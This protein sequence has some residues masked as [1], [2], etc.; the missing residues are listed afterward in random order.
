MS[1]D[2]NIY[3]RYLQGDEAAFDEI[4]GEYRLKLIFF[5]QRI[6]HDPDT[7]E[8]IAIDVFVDLLTH[9]KR[10]DFRLS[11]KNYL[12]MRGRSLALD[13]LRRHKRQTDLT[14][15]EQMTDS[16]DLE[17]QLLLDEE[18]RA[19]NDALK[20]LPEDMQQALHLHY[21]EDLTYE[22]AAYIM[23]CTPKQIDNLLYRGKNRLRSILQKE[24]L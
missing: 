3:R 19:L 23:K 17:Q 6:V 10:Y 12:F 1:A 5:I 16:T 15:L 14:A 21:F 8:D 22:Q 11:L 7:A 9:P 13:H 20:T 24:E 18:K 2:E 4:L